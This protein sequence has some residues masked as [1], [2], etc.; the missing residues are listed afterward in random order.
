MT[1][2]WM[3]WALCPALALPFAL[4]SASTKEAK[5]GTTKSGLVRLRDDAAQEK[6]RDADEADRFDRDAWRAK[7]GAKDLDA[8][9]RDLDAL[10]E[11]A[12]TDDAA[13]DALKE[14]A[15]SEKDRE[16]AWTSRL[17]L[18][19]VEKLPRSL[20]R[21]RTPLGGPGGNAF[22]GPRFDDL[23]KRMEELQQRF[24]SIDSMFGDMQKR[25]DDLLQQP[26]GAAPFGGTFT[27]GN[28]NFSMRSEGFSM[29]SGADG[30]EV[31]VTED[32]NGEQHEKTYKAKTLD[33]LLDAHPELKD[34]IGTDG[35][36]TFR[37]FGGAHPFAGPRG[38]W[39]PLEDDPFQAPAK[40]LLPGAPRTA[41]SNGPVLGIRCSPIGA[42]Q[43]EE[44]GVEDAH[45]L[46][47]ASVEPGSL[48]ERLG[49][50]AGD[51][52]VELDGTA[53]RETADVAKVL[54]ERKESDELRASVIDG[55]KRTRNLKYTPPASK[56]S[57]ESKD[58][59]SAKPEKDERGF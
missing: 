10:I 58:S 31:R 59:K 17:A 25:M 41:P 16:L 44:L 33:E 43:A 1:K 15:S 47:V 49:I 4:Q 9:E 27:P 28:G 54:R 55:K 46:A 53:I 35:G 42:Q 20:A 32:E 12:R 19:E 5:N 30:V 52:L 13:R 3:A 48:A 2:T 22:G 6:A 18:R 57:G 7:L 56:D 36:N 34:R 21:S 39:R 11:L 26:P 24:G 29:Q 40:P 37:F 45:G 51:V 14:W 50:R 23:Q 38:G 8:R